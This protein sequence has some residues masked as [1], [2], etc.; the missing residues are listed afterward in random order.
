MIPIGSFAPHRHVTDTDVDQ[1][2]AA[3]ETLG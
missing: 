3:L 1:L 2:F